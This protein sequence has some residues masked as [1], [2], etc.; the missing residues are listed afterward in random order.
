M[1][2]YARSVTVTLPAEMAK[3]LRAH[4]NEA[5]GWRNTVA[6]QMLRLER[7]QVVTER[8]EAAQLRAVI[9]ALGR[10]SAA[11]TATEETSS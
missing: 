3:T 2:T 5:D 7:S 9:I 6:S 4:L 8:A 1:K 11:L 10:L